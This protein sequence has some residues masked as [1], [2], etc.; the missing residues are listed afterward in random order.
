V[1]AET[2]ENG[3]QTLLYDTIDEAIEH[4]N[5]IRVDTV[6]ADQLGANAQMWASWQDDSAHIGK[7]KRILRMIGA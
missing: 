6:I 3:V 5:R 1:F 2:L 4:V 7:L